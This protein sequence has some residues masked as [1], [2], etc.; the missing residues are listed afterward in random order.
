MRTYCTRPFWGENKTKQTPGKLLKINGGD[1][2]AD[3]RRDR[4]EAK[5]SVMANQLQFQFVARIAWWLLSGCY[6]ECY[7]ARVAVYASFG[8]Q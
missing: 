6:S 2:G 8:I 4:T 1:D 5:L 3:L 7:S